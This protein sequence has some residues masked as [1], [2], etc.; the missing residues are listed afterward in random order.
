[1]VYMYLCGPE[2][3]ADVHGAVLITADFLLDDLPCKGK[4]TC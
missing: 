3:I 1:M 4:I 2:D